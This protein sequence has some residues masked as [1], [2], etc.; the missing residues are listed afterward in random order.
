MELGTRRT[1]DL[2]VRNEADHPSDQVKAQET[3]PPS[4][5]DAQRTSIVPMIVRAERLHAA[6]E[7]GTVVGRR[8]LS[9]VGGER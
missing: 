3:F 9:W 8:S 5:E 1:H 6:K 2:S 4:L 7:I